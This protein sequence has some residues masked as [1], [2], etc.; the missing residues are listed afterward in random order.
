[1]A[2]WRV[3]KRN[4][5]LHLLAPGITTFTVNVKLAEGF[6]WLHAIFFLKFFFSSA[7]VFKNTVH[8]CFERKKI[9]ERF[10]PFA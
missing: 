2:I 6:Q 1:M 3:V 8:R 7:Y 4:Y 10:A 9:H 5:S